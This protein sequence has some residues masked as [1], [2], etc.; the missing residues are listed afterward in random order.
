MQTEDDHCRPIIRHTIALGLAEVD[1][2]ISHKTERRAAAW[3]RHLI[4]FRGHLC[5]SDSP[6]LESNAA[7][8]DPLPAAPLMEFL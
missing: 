1:M 3:R 4:K 6:S 2:S 7:T 8:N 5:G